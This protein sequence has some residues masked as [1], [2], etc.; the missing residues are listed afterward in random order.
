MIGPSQLREVLAANTS[1]IVVI[2]CQMQMRP[3]GV[4]GAADVPNQLALHDGFTARHRQRPKVPISGN[5]PIPML[6]K[7]AIAERPHPTHTMS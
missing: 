3:G 6:N 7:D 4:A 5:P 2:Q 1:I